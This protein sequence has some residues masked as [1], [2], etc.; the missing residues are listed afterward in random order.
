MDHLV[1]QL[2]SVGKA[3]IWGA[4]SWFAL[5][6]TGATDPANAANARDLGREQRDPSG[7]MEM[8]LMAIVSL[9][10]QRVTIYG[11]SGQMLRAP[12][13]SG[14]PGYDT[15]VGIFSVIQK[16][17]EHYSN[18]YDDASMPFMQRLTWSGI[19]LHAG[20]L[21]GHAASHGC[22]RMPHAFAEQLF[23][24]TR[25]GMRVIVARSDIVPRE[26]THPFLFQ[27]SGPAME[28][29]AGSLSDGAAGSDGHGAMAQ[30]GTILTSEAQSPISPFQ[31]I[32]ML[33]AAADKAKDDADAAVRLSDSASL[34]ARKRAAEARHGQTNARF[35]QAMKSRAEAQL[36]TAEHVI[37][38]AASPAMRQMAEAS[39]TKALAKIA[40]LQAQIDAGP[41]SLPERAEA[42]AKAAEEAQT[43]DA[44]KAAARSTAR[45]AARKLLP[46]SVFIS[47]QTQRLFVRRGFEPILEAP[48]TIKDPDRPIGTHIYTALDYSNE[49]APVRWNAVSMTGDRDNLRAAIGKRRKA[50]SDGIGARGSA[51]NAL[52]RIEIAPE[53]RSRISEVVAPGSSLVVS[54][55]MLSTETGD[56]TEFVVVMS[57]E[58]Q[59]GIKIRR[60]ETDD[61]PSTY[62][63]YA[64]PYARSPRSSRRPQVKDGFLE[65]LGTD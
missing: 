42:A 48:V 52:D 17:A 63:G 50:E 64:Q 3:L 39:K 57:G 60:R 16:E 37:E 4:I 20:A 2:R 35:A 47:R 41:G 10:D 18:L 9:R 40:E 34:N 56:A 65:W 31:H 49:A 51:A 14:Q 59:G 32:E 1:T 7:P 54:D 62:R 25:L 30:D 24:M 21:P 26:I 27:P 23:E 22:V 12:V 53:I 58:P 13:S 15:P 38:T 33:K 6:P 55:E 28:E 19:A 46:I 61:S 5:L 45:E 43:A 36:S 8:P 11:A 44:A 29:A